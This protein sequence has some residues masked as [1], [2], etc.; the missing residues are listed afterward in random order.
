MTSP[1]RGRTGGTYQ[2]GD[3]TR[4]EV[5]RDQCLGGLD[6]GRCRVR[7]VPRRRQRRRDRYGHR[8]ER[9]E[10]QRRE[11]PRVRHAL[12]RDGRLRW[13]RRSIP[14]D[15]PRPRQPHAIFSPNTQS[16][17]RTWP[18]ARSTVV[19]TSG[20][21]ALHDDGGNGPDESFEQ[22]VTTSATT[23]SRASTSAPA[24][25]SGEPLVPAPLVAR[26]RVTYQLR[27]TCARAGG[28]SRWDAPPRVRGRT[29][30][31]DVVLPVG[32]YGAGR[33]GCG[34]V[35]RGGSAGRPAPARRTLPRGR[36]PRTTPRR[37]RSWRSP[38]GRTPA[39]ARWRAG[40]A[41]CHSSRRGRT[42]YIASDAPTIRRPRGTPRNRCRRAGR[43]GRWPRYS[44]LHPD[45]SP[46]PSKPTQAGIVPDQMVGKWPISRP[47]GRGLPLVRDR[48][49][50]CGGGQPARSR[51]FRKRSRWPSSSARRCS[52][53][54]VGTHH[55][56]SSI[57]QARSATGIRAARA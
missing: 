22:L 33:A 43:S 9:H 37:A 35:R 5:P 56:G 44:P 20:F 17:T 11:K 25:A 52:T 8:P 38:D 53:V 55:G 23:S 1:R 49:G 30:G 12:H 36:S 34:L 13:G 15:L 27:L 26:Q 21:V 16:P 48:R 54:K 40:S 29:L 46:P 32:R 42:P 19:A 4:R 51:S 7:A 6:P 24:S 50:Q 31:V 47:S 10:A 28:A 18:R 57:V 41:R 3:R 39:S 45:T 14:A 2:A